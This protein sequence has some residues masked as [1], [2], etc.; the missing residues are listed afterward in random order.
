MPIK[1]IIKNEA[2]HAGIFIL[3]ALLFFIA[4]IWLLGSERQIFAKL[5]EYKTQFKDVQGLAEGAPVRLGGISIGRVSGIGFSN[6]LNDPNIHVTLLL[7]NRYTERVKS[8]SII[9]IETQGLLGD[10]FLSL[11]TGLA[12]EQLSPGAEI[13]S[14]EPSNIADVMQKAGTI[15]DSTVKIS[16][17]INAFVKEFRGESSKDL[18]LAIKSI[19]DILSNVKNGNG[20]VHKLIYSD[21]D[22]SNILRNLERSSAYISNI[23]A[24]IRKGNGILHGLIYGKT[25][26][27][28]V[29]SVTVAASNLAKTAELITSIALEIKSGSGL[30]HDLVYKKS[31]AGL[32]D[33]FAKLNSAANNLVKASEALAQGSGTIGALLVDSQLYDN[34]VEV[35]DGAKRSF[36]LRQAIKGAMDK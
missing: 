36:L 33:I 10:K 24:Q 23:T 11:S 34:L 1:F 7:N 6:N 31:S 30:I 25:G 19:S 27:D 4:S 9:S 22:G 35:T 16:E 26:A 12:S 13:K 14:H 15:V 18:S 21:K 17:E 3:A 20:L 8:D 2:F 32:S 5:A 28:A 29:Q